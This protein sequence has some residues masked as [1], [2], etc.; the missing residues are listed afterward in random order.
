M[1]LAINASFRNKE[2]TRF[3]VLMHVSDLILNDSSMHVKAKKKIK[4]TSFIKNCSPLK[5]F[6]F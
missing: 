3:S 6:N 4:K 1:H 5:L 2:V